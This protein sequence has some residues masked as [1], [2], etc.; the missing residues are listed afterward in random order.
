MAPRLASQ[1]TFPPHALDGFSCHAE[2]VRATYKYKHLKAA[3]TNVAQ[4]EPWSAKVEAAPLHVHRDLRTE[5]LQL[6]VVQVAISSRGVL[7]VTHML[8]LVAGALPMPVEVQPLLGTLTS[9]VLFVRAPRRCAAWSLHGCW[10]LFMHGCLPCWRFAQQGGCC[11]A[12]TR[13]A[14]A[15]CRVMRSARVSSCL[16]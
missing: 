4:K 8:T 11:A 9:Q 14:H 2:E 7:R 1:I 5:R 12:L 3:F 13:G 6:F 15:C 10:A 16:W